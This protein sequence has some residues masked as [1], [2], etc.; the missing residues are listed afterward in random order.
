MIWIAPSEKD[1][2][3]EALDK[4]LW[5]T[6]SQ[7]GTSLRTDGKEEEPEKHSALRR[8]FQGVWL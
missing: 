8:W 6:A 5:A 3:S 4:R 7:R 2:D 1:Q